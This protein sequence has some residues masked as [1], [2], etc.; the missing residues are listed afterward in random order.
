M[1]TLILNEIKWDLEN[2]SICNDKCDDCYHH[3][4]EGCALIYNHAPV[5]KARNNHLYSLSLS[6]LTGKVDLFMEMPLTLFK[7]ITDSNVIRGE[8]ELDPIY[9]PHVDIIR[10]S[11]HVVF[12]SRGQY[13]L[14]PSDIDIDQYKSAETDYF[15]IHWPYAYGEYYLQYSFPLTPPPKGWWNDPD[16]LIR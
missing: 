4:D 14:L 2:M 13:R 1:L 16:L 3:V 10:T 8:L 15:N 7:R 12:Q 11:N 9:K 6:R 5:F